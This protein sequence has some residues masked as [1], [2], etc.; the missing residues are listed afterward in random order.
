MLSLS[1]WAVWMYKSSC[2]SNL[3]FSFKVFH[4]AHEDDAV[5]VHLWCALLNKVVDSRRNVILDLG[6]QLLGSEPWTD[7]LTIGEFVIDAFEVYESTSSEVSV[8]ATFFP[9]LPC[10]K[11]DHGS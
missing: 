5:E 7:A 10:P 8:S 2:L 11:T 6:Q 9:N 3:S 1:S 4:H